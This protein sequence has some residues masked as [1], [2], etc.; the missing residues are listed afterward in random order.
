MKA[1]AHV[2][3][4]TPTIPVPAVSKLA[5]ATARLASNNDVITDA[6]I[7]ELAYKLYEEPGRVGNDLQDWFEAEAILRER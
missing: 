6:Q 3:R 7:Q 4:E 5:S 1:K 2:Q